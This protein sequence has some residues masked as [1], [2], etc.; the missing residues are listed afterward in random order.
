MK[1]ESLPRFREHFEHLENLRRAAAAGDLE[2]AEMEPS[3]HAFVA[4]LIA[5]QFVHG[6]STLN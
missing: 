1:P 2:A 5:P 6:P 4:A 3:F